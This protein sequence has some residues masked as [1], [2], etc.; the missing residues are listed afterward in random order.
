MFGSLRLLLAIAVA[1]SHA[2]FSWQERHI[3]V[4]AVIVFLMLSGYVV[5]GLL[6]QGGHLAASPLRFYMER[7]ARLL[8]LYYLYLLVGL[9]A[10]LWG[11][12]SP[13]LQGSGTVLQILSNLLVI[14]LNYSMFIEPLDTYQLVP[15]AWSLGLEIQFYLLAPWLLARQERLLA[16]LV[17]S[18]AVGASAQLGYLH[19]DWFGYRL[20]CGNLY[21]FLS[22]VWLYRIHHGT[23][24]FTPL[25]GIWVITL[26][27]YMVVG[28]QGR[29]GTPFAFEVLTGYLIGLPLVAW[30]GRQTRRKWDDDLGQLAYGVFLGHFSILWLLQELGWP[31]ITLELMPLYIALAIGSAYIG[32]QLVERPLLDWRRRLR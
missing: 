9:G 21:I 10:V 14:P 17:L 31:T 23:A 27:L 26:L 11:V 19:T 6:A 7:A 13:F 22:G 16:G 28:Y 18:L 12:G 20:L 2:G 29:W 15:P 8:P 3:G 1:L 32:H 25:L 24:K 30:L 5:A 4:M